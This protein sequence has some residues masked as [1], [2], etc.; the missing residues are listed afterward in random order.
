M[1]HRKH[2][3]RKIDAKNAVGLAKFASERALL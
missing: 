3:L 2:L 1:T